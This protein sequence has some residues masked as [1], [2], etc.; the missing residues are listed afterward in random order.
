MRSPI[1]LRKLGASPL[2][3]SPLGL[4]CMGMTDFYGEPDD[5][6]SVRTIHRAV[7]LGLNFLDTADVYGPLTNELL[8][9]RALRE[10]PPR[11]PADPPLVIATKFGLLR[12]PAPGKQ[13]L[14]ARGDPE[15]VRQSCDA[16][17]ARLGVETIDL[18]YAHRITAETPVEVTV[19]AMAELVRAGKVRALGLSE[20]SPATLRRA[21]AVH[22]I[23]ALQSEYSLWTRDPEQNETLD[24]CREL[25]VAFVA[26]SPLGRGFLTGAIPNIETLPQSDARRT[27]PRFQ[28]D[29]FD[30]NLRIAQM[31]RELAQ[32]KGCQPAQ[33]ALAWL[34]ARNDP[35]LSPSPGPDGGR[36]GFCVIPIPGVKRRSHLEQNIAALDLHLSPADLS[37][38][39]SLFPPGAASG[40]RYPPNRMAELNR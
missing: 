25:G 1:T 23:A 32:A 5:D 27:H 28:G 34:L 12:A 8:I 20:V 37:M 31:V 24:T 17:L 6:E 35:D 33:L 13:W 9:A 36:D 14:G 29:N 38:I 11:S 30:R 21:H 15:Y 40:D 26:Y 2:L 16:S 7:D 39:D 4:G 18:F 19:A 10:L 22:P 3:V